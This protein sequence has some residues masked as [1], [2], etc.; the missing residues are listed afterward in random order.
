MKQLEECRKAIEPIVIRQNDCWYDTKTIATAVYVILTYMIE[1]ERKGEPLTAEEETKL[2]DALGGGEFYP[3]PRKDEPRTCENCKHYD[4]K[5]EAI[6][7]ERCLD[8]KYSR[9]EPKDEPQTDA[10]CENCKHYG[11]ESVS[12]DRCDKS[13]HNR[14]EPKGARNVSNRP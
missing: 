12:C 1:A 13:R 9:Y 10:R 8:G 3:K 7:C 2:L 5:V 4:E 14:F 11:V 6:A